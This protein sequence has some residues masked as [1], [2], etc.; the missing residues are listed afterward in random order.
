MNITI[1]HSQTEKD[2]VMSLG[3]SACRHRSHHYSSYFI[4]SLHICICGPGIFRQV[5]LPVG[6][7]SPL[8]RT[9]F[10][11]S[12]LLIPGDQTNQ[13]REVMAVYLLH[14]TVRAGLNEREAPGK[15]MTVR[16]PKRLAQLRS[17]SRA[18]GV[19]MYGGSYVVNFFK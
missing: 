11:L 13:L 6:F 7:R 15:V 17:V 2:F 8:S 18:L 4:C 16:P 9:T 12:R 3:F 5:F 10:G 1:K 14:R 19:T